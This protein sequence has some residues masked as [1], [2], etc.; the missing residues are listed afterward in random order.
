MSSNLRIVKICAFCKQEFIARKTT[1][2][3]CSDPCA[4]RFYK[5]KKRL[6]EMAQ[7]NL[8]MEIQRWPGAFVVE[9]VGAIGKGGFGMD[10]EEALV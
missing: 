5:E 7:A 3:I 9:A 1:A 2:E 4:K 8:K 6:E 10:E